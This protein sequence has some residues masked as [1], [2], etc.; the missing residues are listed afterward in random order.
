MK[1][2]LI[3]AAVLVTL[4]LT[5][6]LA[7]AVNCPNGHSVDGYHFT[8]VTLYSSEVYHAI[9]K[10]WVCPYCGAVAEQLDHR[11]RHSFSGTN[12]TICGGSRHEKEVY[13]SEAIRRGS[14]VIGRQLFVMW[15]GDI[16][17]SINGG[18]LYS[19][20]VFDQYYVNDYQF[21]NGT[22]WI[23]VSDPART[24]A[25]VGWMKAE[26]AS[27]NPTPVTVP[28]D[29]LIGRRVKITTSSGRARA[30]AGTEYPV[31]EYVR[32]GE[33]YEILD[34]ASASNGTQ[35]YMLN[36][37]GTNCWVSSGLCDITY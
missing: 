4:C 29:I 10:H 7:M 3:L 34:V 26:I 12:C 25:P 33:Y 8:Y 1:K 36:V 18:R 19:V 24:Y 28:T 22:P 5:P 31:L 35:W 15:E 17:N 37:S 30:G 27:I 32:Y 21:V 16:Y 11:E 2:V 6:V 13:R 14:D 9:N 23:Q 20:S